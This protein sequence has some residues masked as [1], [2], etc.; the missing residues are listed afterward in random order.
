M[1]GFTSFTDLRPDPKY[2]MIKTSSNNNH[3]LHAEVLIQV[4]KE[5]V[6][7]VLLPF[8]PV[9]MIFTYNKEDEVR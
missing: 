5:K 6:T 4:V 8:F 2:M 1:R 9:R 7:V 3:L